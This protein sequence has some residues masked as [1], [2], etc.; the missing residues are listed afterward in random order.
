MKHWLLKTEP[1]E[2]GWAEQVAAS[3]SEW[4]GIRN[5]QARNNLRAM[6][7]GDRAF[8]Y[9]TGHEKAIVGIV[10]ITRLAAPDSTSDDPRWDAVWVR[11]LQA[12]PRPVT[13]VECRAHTDLLDMALVKSPR[14]SVQPVSD[15]HW[16][17]ICGLGGL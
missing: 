7:L 14:L 12:L 11:S 16:R 3:E 8:F 5:Y 10:E 4:G 1:D 2:F 6:A 13:L 15:V 9:H 17:I